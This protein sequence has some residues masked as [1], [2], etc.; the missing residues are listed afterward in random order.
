MSRLNTCRYYAVGAVLLFCVAFLIGSSLTWPTQTPKKSYET[1]QLA[2]V[3]IRDAGGTGSGAVVR[4]TNAQGSTRLFIWTAAHVVSDSDEVIIE[5]KVRNEYRKVGT[6]SFKARVVMRAPAEDIALLW[7]DAP[8]GFFNHVEFDDVEQRELGAEVFHVGNFLGTLDDSLSWGRISQFG[9]DGGTLWRSVDQADMLILP[10]SSGGPMFSYDS[11]KV[12]GI[13]VGWPRQPGVNF[14]VPLRTIRGVA[15]RE[16]VYWAIYGAYAPED[17]ALDKFVEKSKLTKDE[18]V[19][20]TK[21]EPPE[22][23]KSAGPKKPLR[24]FTFKGW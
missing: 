5:T 12:L 18:S 24:R 17:S 14:Y 2:T 15:R 22:S 8:D 11:R 1:E 19:P 21:P 3:I 4:R 7:L 10:G 20:A 9:I 16:S 6:V 23:K 13:V